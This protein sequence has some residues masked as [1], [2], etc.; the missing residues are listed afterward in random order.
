MIFE[1][2]KKDQIHLNTEYRLEDRFLCLRLRNLTR[3]ILFLIQPLVVSMWLW[4]DS[5]RFAHNANR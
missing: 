3:R 1:I 2:I 4:L 5:L